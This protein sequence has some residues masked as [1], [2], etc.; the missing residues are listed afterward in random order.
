MFE[1]D[2]IA[3]KVDITTVANTGECM[4]EPLFTELVQRITDQFMQLTEVKF[5]WK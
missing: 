3:F 2:I 4:L 1:A 5:K